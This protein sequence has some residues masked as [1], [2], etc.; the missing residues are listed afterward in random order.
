MISNRIPLSTQPY[1]SHGSPL[2]LNQAPSPDPAAARREVCVHLAS[3]ADRVF[4]DLRRFN[5]A[6]MY[7]TYHAIIATGV[8][9]R[10]GYVIPLPYL[11]QIF[12]AL[13]T[14]Y[15]L[16]AINEKEISN[17]NL[18]RAKSEEEVISFGI[19]LHILS[20]HKQLSTIGTR[21]QIDGGAVFD[22]AGMFSS[23]VTMTVQRAS[24]LLTQLDALIEDL[25]IV[26]GWDGIIEAWKDIS[27]TP[28]HNHPFIDIYIG[29]SYRDLSTIIGSLENLRS[30]LDVFTINTDDT[31]NGVP[32]IEA[33]EQL[34][35]AL[36]GY[37]ES[38]KGILVTVKLR[39]LTGRGYSLL[40][41]RWSLD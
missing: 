37:R 16:Y 6:H 28:F 4:R 17:E 11:N 8:L 19:T 38:L 21:L 22:E 10:C 41:G 25:R 26:H 34:S 39:D 29:Y 7:S 20:L 36:N 18:N 3:Q 9:T 5:E 13:G 1:P 12:M 40:T 23:D 24:S 30:A 27:E 31:G 14:V 35:R 32:V 15:F 33:L 2:T